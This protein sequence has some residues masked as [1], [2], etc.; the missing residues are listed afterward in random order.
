MFCRRREP[1]QIF[2]VTV[3][4]NGRHPY[5]KDNHLDHPSRDVVLIVPAFDWN[6]AETQAMSAARELPDK[7][8][9]RVT[10]ISRFNE[11]QVS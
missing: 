9:W 7:W 6:D 2:E 1:T 4:L 3:H 10:A 8:S 11:A 5:L